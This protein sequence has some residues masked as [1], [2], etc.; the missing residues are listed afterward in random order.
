VVKPGTAPNSIKLKEAAIVSLEL[1]LA[2]TQGTGGHNY[3]SDHEKLSGDTVCSKEFWE[4]VAGCALRPAVAHL[5]AFLPP[6]FE[7]LDQSYGLLPI[8]ADAF[9]EIFDD[10]TPWL[11]FDG[12]R[13]RGLVESMLAEQIMYFERRKNRYGSSFLPVSKLVGV[14]ADKLRISRTVADAMLCR[15]GSLVHGKFV[16]DNQPSLV[17]SSLVTTLTSLSSNVA[18]L[19]GSVA[20]LTAAAECTGAS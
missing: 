20:S 2:S 11:S 16:A 18:E 7:G 19:G 1:Y 9:F 4:G 6:P 14:V 5:G 13:L 3:P 8:I 17:D 10:I 12:G 15:W